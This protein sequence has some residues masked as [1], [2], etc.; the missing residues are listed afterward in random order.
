VANNKSFGE[1]GEDYAVLYLKRKG[2]KIINRNF[3]SRFGEIDII[4]TEGTT[5]VFV[6]VKSRYSN[7]FGEPVEA[8]T[9]TKLKKIIMTGYYYIQKN[10][11]KAPK[12]RV[13]VVSINRVG[14]KVRCKLI[15]VY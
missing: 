7:K 2:Y 13:D 1:W 14:N 11:L 3:S 15:Q 12:M 5:L 4:A 9:P 10:K 6:E 8:V